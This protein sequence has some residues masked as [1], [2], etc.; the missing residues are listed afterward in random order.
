MD[1]GALEARHTEGGGLGASGYVGTEGVTWSS[2]ADRARTSSGLGM[3]VS[4]ATA[5]FTTHLQF[6]RLE[7]GAAAGVLAS[8]WEGDSSNSLQSRTALA[9]D[10][11]R[12][13]REK[14][15]PIRPIPKNSGTNQGGPK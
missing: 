9:D 7:S 15:C 6:S 1:V 11:P 8:T 12:H 2:K 4:G 5:V 3:L 10:R 14:T 13:S